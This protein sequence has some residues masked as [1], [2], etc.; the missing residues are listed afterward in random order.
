MA[1]R[2]RLSYKGHFIEE[3]VD[4]NKIRAYFNF[5]K[6]YNHLYEDFTFDSEALE[7][8]EEEAM[9][10]ANEGIPT[11]EDEEDEE[12]IQVDPGKALHA[13]KSLIVNKYREDTNQNTVVAKFADMV[14][15][16]EQLQNEDN[17]GDEEQ[18]DPEHENFPEDELD[19]L[20]DD[21]EDEGG[22]SVYLE[23]L[24]AEDVEIA[25]EYAKSVKVLNQV[26]KLNLNNCCKCS[27]TKLL[28]KIVTIQSGLF[29]LKAESSFLKNLIDSKL[30]SADTLMGEMKETSNLLEPCSHNF[31]EISNFL[32]DFVFNKKK[33]PG[34]IRKYVE[35]QKNLIDESLK[36][37]S[38]APGEK[39]QFQNWGSDVF[40]E[41]KLFPHLYAFGLGG[42][43]SSNVLRRG[44]MGFSNYV[45]T[46]LQ[47]V[48]A[49]FREDPFYVFFLLLVKELVEI[50]R[51]EKTFFRK[52]TK[53]PKL[54]ASSITDT[55][56]EFLM[57]NN[58]AFTTYK[59]IRGS[60]MYFEAVK[61]NLI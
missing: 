10:E 7:K 18:L 49:K 44:N 2:R 6:K 59:S 19:V 48:N 40:L 61:K 8:F 38:V 57:R 23:D 30:S 22:E 60:A 42:Y 41:E 35:Q 53:V 39:G 24:T 16:F 54:N 20:E 1:F 36:K 25:K 43:L 56:K 21:D 58:N 29:K 4:K 12:D 51:S 31:N 52:A 37:I 47:S 14:V 50:K 27:L 9:K 17:I 34:D 32:N 13:L 3:F 26:L 45:K 15:Q 46:R 28:A 55:N 11:E 5:F 33:L